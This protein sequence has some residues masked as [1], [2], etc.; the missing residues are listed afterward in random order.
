MIIKDLIA[1]GADMNAHTNDGESALGWARR[2]NKLEVVAFLH[3][4]G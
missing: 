2:Y 4:L 3:N 1:K